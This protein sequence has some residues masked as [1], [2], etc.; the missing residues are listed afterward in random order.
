M[1]TIDDEQRRRAWVTGLPFKLAQGRNELLRKLDD[2]I[3]ALNMHPECRGPTRITFI[4][5]LGT[6]RLLNTVERLEQF[7]AKVMRSSGWTGNHREHADVARREYKAAGCRGNPVRNSFHEAVVE[8]ANAERTLEAELKN[9][10]WRM[11]QHL[12][13]EKRL[14]MEQRAAVNDWETTRREV[15]ALTIKH[16]EAQLASAYA[17]GECAEFEAYLA[18]EKAN[19]EPTQ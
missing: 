18:G 13:R 15:H 19:H 16:K 9:A 5:S 12:D 11:Q 6:Y 2:Q 4:T 14:A 17:R 3:K 1:T 8:T 10:N 7:R